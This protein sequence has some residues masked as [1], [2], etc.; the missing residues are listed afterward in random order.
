M[1]IINFV[2][3]VPAILMT[4][5]LF[6]LGIGP[7]G[8][9]LA[10]IAACAIFPGAVGEMLRLSTSGAAGGYAGWVL[11]YL[12]TVTTFMKLLDMDYFETI[13]CSAVIFVIRTWIGYALLF[14][15]M[16]GIRTPGAGSFADIPD[17]GAGRITLAGDTWSE[18]EDEPALDRA[19]AKRSDDYYIEQLHAGGVEA[20]A[21]IEGKD[22]RTLAGQSRD[23][24]LD[25]VRGIYDAGA[26]EIRAYPVRR[27]GKPES[28]NELIVIAPE[29]GAARARTF[30]RLKALAK[31]LDRTKARDRGEKY[32]PIRMSREVPDAGPLDPDDFK[33]P[34]GPDDEK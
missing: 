20:G 27:K 21:W 3:T 30:D 4:I 29:D 22:D 15:I 26:K 11:S 31:Q 14:A 33:G 28:A 9:G 19:H 8:P 2:L 17:Q 25:I 5:R 18:E 10:K 6:D 16:S 12:I 24:S 23:K 13:V 1:T 32:W 34:A 7:V